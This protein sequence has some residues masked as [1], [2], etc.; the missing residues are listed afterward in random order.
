ME[1]QLELFHK[2]PVPLDTDAADRLTTQVNQLISLQ[3]DVLS[4]FAGF[5]KA[6]DEARGDEEY[7]KKDALFF[8]F[9][10]VVFPYFALKCCT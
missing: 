6:V 1:Q 8:I 10:F 5:P 7:D 3:R 4:L 2:H 9:F